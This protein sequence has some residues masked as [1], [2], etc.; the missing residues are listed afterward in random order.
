[1]TTGTRDDY[2]IDK[3][4]YIFLRNNLILVVSYIVYIFHAKLAS[5]R[6]S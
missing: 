1:M 6:F 5:K 3:T 2:Y 4:M